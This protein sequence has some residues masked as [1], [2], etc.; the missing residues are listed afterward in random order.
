[1][2][3]WLNLEQT[4]RE[5][6]KMLQDLYTQTAAEIPNDAARQRTFFIRKLIEKSPGSSF[7]G[8]MGTVVLPNKMLAHFN[9]KFVI[10]RIEETGKISVNYFLKQGMFVCSNG[11]NSVGGLI[12]KANP[13]QS[14][15][16][17]VDIDA[18]K[19]EAEKILGDRSVTANSA[20]EAVINDA[21]QLLAVTNK[22]RMD[23]YAGQIGRFPRCPE[24][25]PQHSGEGIPGASPGRVPAGGRRNEKVQWHEEGFGAAFVTESGD[26]TTPENRGGRWPFSAVRGYHQAGMACCGYQPDKNEKE[27]KERPAQ[28]P[29]H[30]RFP[31]LIQ[32]PGFIRFPPLLRFPELIR[33]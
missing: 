4:A 7:N 27:R 30:V 26:Q 9:D 33:I 6:E 14:V 10:D 3:Y 31:P 22:T 11:T 24:K 13:G 19:A 18:M 25:C 32:F 23:I 16:T 1:M 12:N 15:F 17:K 28:I 21:Y 29:R 8:V 5:T 2:K 20:E